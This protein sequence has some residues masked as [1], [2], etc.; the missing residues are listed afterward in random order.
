MTYEEKIATFKGL[1][2]FVKTDEDLKDP[3]NQHAFDVIAE[4]L[5]NILNQ[6]ELHSDYDDLLADS[7]K[8]D[9]IENLLIS[10]MQQ[11]AEKKIAL[12]KAIE[13]EEEY[14]WGD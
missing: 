3:N 14:P 1:E 4:R 2:V 12:D 10:R 7:A 9:T 6:I 13:D 5:K 8:L 11:D